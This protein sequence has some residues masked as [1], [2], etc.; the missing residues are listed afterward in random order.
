MYGNAGKNKQ[1]QQLCKPSIAT[2]GMLL[3]NKANMMLRKTRT[4]QIV[5]K[6]G[7]E[8]TSNGIK[9]ESFFE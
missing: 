1:R 5:E 9:E 6:S 2:I 8:G 7:R 4:L 3:E